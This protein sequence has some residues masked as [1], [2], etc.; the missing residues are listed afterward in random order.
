[1]IL[2]LL[3]FGWWADEDDDDKGLHVADDD[4]FDWLFNKLLLEWTVVML[5]CESF[6]E[7]NE[8]TPPEINV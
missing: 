4:E 1:M 8:D 3:L 7:L 5:L 6:E 2:L